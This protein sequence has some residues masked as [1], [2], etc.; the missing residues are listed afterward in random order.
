MKSAAP[1]F[2]PLAHLYMVEDLD[3]DVRDVQ[4]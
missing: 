4:P 2:H 3:A 1:T